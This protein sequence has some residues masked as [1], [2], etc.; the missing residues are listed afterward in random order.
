VTSGTETPKLPFAPFIHDGFGQDA[1]RGI[2]GAEE[3]HVVD[4]VGHVH[5][6]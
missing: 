3:Q 5:L 2:A 1:P 6:A 4:L